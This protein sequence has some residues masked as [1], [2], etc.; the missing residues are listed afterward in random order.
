[1]AFV[2]GHH[3]NDEKEDEK[4]ESLAK[5]I[6]TLAIYMGVGNLQYIRAQLLK[7][8]KSDDTPIALIHW[9]TTAVQKTVTGTLA[10][11]LDI[12]REEKIKNPSMI[13]IGEVVHF[14][15]KIKWFKELGNSS[16]ISEAL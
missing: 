9:G 7:Y 11:I 16:P 10:T 14:R 1:M 8:G 15:K 6:D 13:I 12:V 3:Q 2:T 4:W 5:G